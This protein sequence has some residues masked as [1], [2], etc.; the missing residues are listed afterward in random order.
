MKPA[1]M[2]SAGCPVRL[3]WHV[4][5]QTVGISVLPLISENGKIQ[6][7][8]TREHVTLSDIASR[9]WPCRLNYCHWLLG[10]FHQLLGSNQDGVCEKSCK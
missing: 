5:A 6:F 7:L 10:T 4:F 1:L 3:N 8:N 9:R 2:V